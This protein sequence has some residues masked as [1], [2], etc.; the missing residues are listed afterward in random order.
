MARWTEGCHNAA[1]LYREIVQQGYPGGITIVKDFVTTL[2]R[3]KTGEPV[4]RHV[5][6][7][8][9]RLR[10]WFTCPAEK[11]GEGE[12]R[13]LESVLE[14]SPVVREAYTLLQDFRKVLTEKKPQALRA[15]LEQALRSSLPPIR[16]FARS[17]EQDMDAVMNAVTLPWS[18]GPVEGHINKLKLLKRQMYGRAGIEL[19]RRRFLAMRS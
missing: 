5:R 12:R 11:L 2:R 9:K 14:T 18:N 13:L 1:E 7:G 4:I 15:W 19:L 8:L 16:G 10:K 3:R 17:L 6:L